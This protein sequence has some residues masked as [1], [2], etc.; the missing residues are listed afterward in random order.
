MIIWRLIS[1]EFLKFNL[2]I[3]VFFVSVYSVVDFLEKN[4]RY[5]PKYKAEN[6]VIAEFYLFQIPFILVNLLPFSCMIAA[7]ITL[8]TFAK[9]GEVSALRAA[10]QSIKKIC[11]PLIVWGFIFTGIQ[12]VLAEFVVPSTSL[13]LKYIETVKI[14]KSEFGAI[15]R[16][17]NWIRGENSLI[18]FQK[19]IGAQILVNPQYYDFEDPANIRS[20]TIAPRASFDPDKGNWIMENAVSTHFADKRRI[21]TIRYERFPTRIFSKPPKLLADWISPEQVSYRDLRELIH[22]AKKTGGPLSERYVDLY[23]KLSLPF[24]NLLFVILAMPFA[25]QRERQAD[26]Y[27]GII[28]C[29]VVAIVYWV[30]N[31]TMRGLAQGGTLNPIFAAWFVDIVF[32]ICL[33]FMMRRLD[34]GF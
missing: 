16:E 27:I 15:F 2:Y 33:L 26:T 8:W 4:T 13:R 11:A 21:K 5:F 28:F 3:V 22:Q 20:I 31:L 9:H 23:Q 29:L 19:I 14:E 25:L 12:F 7:I 30:A 1:K 18:G 17:G 6:L 32:A 24:A 34:R 10:G